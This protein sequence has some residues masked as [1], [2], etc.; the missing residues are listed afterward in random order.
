MVGRCLYLPVAGLAVSL[1][2][3]PASAA[4]ANALTGV[5]K[6]QASV[7]EQA[8]RRCY[9]HRGHLR[10][11]RL[12]YVGR[13]RGY[14]YGSRWHTEDPSGM[15]VGSHRWWRAKDREGSTGRP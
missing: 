14:G 3:A 5:G 2:A 4:P 15:R 1:L 11:H 6:E 12:G 13:Y 9:R 8:A 10:C 7:V